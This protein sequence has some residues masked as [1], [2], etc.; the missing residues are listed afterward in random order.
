MNDLHSHVAAA[1]PLPTHRVWVDEPVNFSTHRIGRLHHNFHEHPLLQMPRLAELAKSLVPSGQCRFLRPGTTQASVFSHDPKDPAGRTI[2]EVF[3]RIEEPGSWVALYNVET[4]PRY[5]ALLTEILSTVQPLIEREQPGIFMTAGFIFISAPPSVTPFHVDR[6][7]NFWLQLRGRKTMNVWESSDRSVVPASAVEE[8]IIT[9][10]QV[11]FQET[12][13]SRS[14][15]FEVGPGEGVYF[16]STSPHMTRSVPDWVRPGDG[17]AVS[18]GVNFYTSVTRRTAQVHQANN[19][20]R[21]VLRLSPDL[22]GVSPAWDA[23]KAPV[24]R[25]LA[26]LRYRRRHMTPP[27]G[28]Y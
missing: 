24:G 3:E 22:P 12:F 10:S 4:D 7:N 28:A 20:L 2:E 21:R 8:F 9:G 11:P 25:V 26:P 16:P 19:L 1:T 14:H 5:N 13:R 17:V 15:E 27:P 18:F 23:V 6:E